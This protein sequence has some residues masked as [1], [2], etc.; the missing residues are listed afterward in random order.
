MPKITKEHNLLKKLVG[1]WSCTLHDGT[2]SKEIIRAVGDFWIVSES[3]AIAKGKLHQFILTVGYDVNKKKFV[4]SWFSSVMTSL[5]TYEGFFEDG[6]IILE[7]EGE[8]MQDKTKTCLYRDCIELVDDNTKI[9]SSSY[10]NADKNW[11]E[12]SR[13]TYTRMSSE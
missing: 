12:F 4:G 2:P 10:Q 13:T 11:V 5:W 7:T 9:F 8:D 3:E 1:T 6:K